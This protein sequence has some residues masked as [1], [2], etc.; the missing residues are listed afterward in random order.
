MVMMCFVLDLRSLSSPLLRDLKQSLLQLANFYAISSPSSG[1]GRAGSKPLLDR[2]GVCY[3]VTGRISRSSEL[4]V[5]YSPRG[6]FSLR[7]FHHAV[8][9]I[10]TDAFS[11]E[12]SSCGA[13]CCDDAKLSSILS[14]QFLYSWGGHEKDIARK[15]IVVG[16]CPVESLD[17]VTKKTLMD[18]AEKCVSVEFLLLEQRSSYVG[19]LPESINSFVKDICELENCS[20]RTYLP[21]AQV[22]NALVKRWLQDL[23]DDMEE[24]LHA[25]FMFK[26]NLVGTLSH[27]SCNLGTSFNQILDGFITCQTC[28]CHGMP[29]EERRYKKMPSACPVTGDSLGDFD[30]IENSVKVGEQ[31]I[32]FMPS[33][34]CCEELHQV[35]SPI[36]FDV[37]KRTSLMS[38]SEGAILGTSCIVTPSTWHESDEVDKSELNT[39]VFQGLCSVLHSLDQ[40]LVCSS[41]SNIETLGETSFRC[42][43]ILLP[44]DTGLMLLRRLA[45]S[46]EALPLPDVSQLFDSMVPKDIENSVRASLK[47]MEVSDYNPLL[48]E[49]GF[50]Q[51][52][53]LLVKESLQFGSLPPKMKDVTS[54][55]NSTQQEFPE[56]G[57]PAVEATQVV[58]IEEEIPQ[59]DL[60]VGEHISTECITEE[61]EQ[62]IVN[63]VPNRYSPTCISKPKLDQLVLSLPE[64]NRQ[65]DEKTSRILE[66]LEVP[67]KLKTKVASPSIA[68]ACVST[69]KPLIPFGPSHAADRAPTSSQPIKPNFQRPKR[70]QR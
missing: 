3:V 17:T 22:F 24:Q 52:L 35:S 44:S 11:P 33:F 40:G 29:L 65:L 54:E 16:S 42:Y 7:D 51:K 46:E 38:L 9:N 55:L 23:K 66:R 28:R 10:P 36:D 47:K 61:W 49:R 67:R 15:V 57:V 32:L 30:L 26:N 8:N 5:A 14:N 59:M 2:I 56:D 1:S 53:N 43:Y 34:H 39:Q 6:N 60:K 20:F 27:I 19:D 41:T 25:R 4:K 13:M 64:N 12:F 21:D 31:T 58:V 68:D 37:I 70:K 63:E 45:G 18:A 50:H 62:L 48:H 69:K